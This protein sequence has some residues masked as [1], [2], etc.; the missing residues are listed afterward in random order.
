MN[1]MPDRD[2]EAPTGQIARALAVLEAVAAGG[3][4]TARTIAEATAIPLPTVYRT[5]QELIRAGYLVHLRDEQ[6]FALGYQLHRLAVGLH[7]DLGIP[8][9]VREEVHAMFRDLGMAAYL[10]IH[11]GTDFVVV[12]VSDSP[13]SPRLSP[14]G[15][16]FHESPHA[17]AFGKVGLSALTPEDRDA[18]LDRGELRAHTANTLTDP[19]ELRR[20]LDEIADRG[21]AWEHEEFQRG[22]DCLAASIKADDGMLIGTVAVSAPVTAYAG[23]TRHVE[24]RVRACASR[25][26][27]AYRLGAHHS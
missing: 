25:A 12:H 19:E 22:T 2:E 21:I 4:S 15:F 6:R 7:D 9:S 5:A 1:T 17:T 14:M 16:G 27:R 10:A 3:S 18:Y 20:H 23:R 26:G 8:R 24:D 13:Q 11:R